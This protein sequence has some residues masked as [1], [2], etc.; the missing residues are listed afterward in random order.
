[1]NIEHSLS[2]LS[3]LAIIG[4]VWLP[5]PGADRHAVSNMGRVLGLEQPGRRF[6]PPSIQCNNKANKNPRFV[7]WWA[8]SQDTPVGRVVLHTFD[9]PS[10][11]MDRAVRHSK[12]CDWLC[13]LDN[14]EWASDRRARMALDVLWRIGESRTM[15]EAIEASG[16]AVGYFNTTILAD[17]ER[18]P[19]IG[20]RPRRRRGL[21]PE[22]RVRAIR[23]CDEAMQG[24]NARR[25]KAL[26]RATRW[27]A[28][29]WSVSPM[30]RNA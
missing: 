17:L 22:W 1:M 18:N 25:C 2:E 28:Q 4:E 8:G 12:A 15:T 29:G 24:V 27:P 30:K 16:V 10:K 21:D 11:P 7:G 6:L 26:S 20:R 9:R 19:K 23:A 14:M 3:H 13:S 5:I